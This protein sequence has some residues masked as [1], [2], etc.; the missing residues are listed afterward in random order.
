MLAASLSCTLQGVPI[1]AGF[2]KS[3]S[4]LLCDRTV[5][6]A[7]RSVPEPA[8]VQEAA[9]WSVPLLPPELVPRAQLTGTA[10]RSAGCSRLRAELCLP[11]PRAPSRGAA[12]VA[13]AKHWVPGGPGSTR[14]CRAGARA[15]AAAVCDIE[16]CCPWLSEARAAREGLG[17][18]GDF[19]AL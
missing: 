6:A 9:A 16:T 8:P 19:R 5:A 17:L 12:A 3:C 10:L 2:P 14:S 4:P 1:K 18:R 7:R 13:R 11:V 15:V